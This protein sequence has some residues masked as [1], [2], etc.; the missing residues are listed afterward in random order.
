[1]W[2]NLVLGEVGFGD[3]VLCRLAWVEDVVELGAML[4]DLVP[5]V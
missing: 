4:L 1:M 2:L 3:L 5:G